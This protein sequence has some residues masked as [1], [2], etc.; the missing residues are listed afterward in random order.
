VPSRSIIAKFIL[1]SAPRAGGLTK[2]R[3]INGQENFLS[4]KILKTIEKISIFL[5]VVVG[6]VGLAG[7]RPV[8]A[9]RSAVRRRFGCSPEKIS[10]QKSSSKIFCS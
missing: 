1:F 2:P 3:G 7:R 9:A 6:A 4:R 5:L 10:C 8:E